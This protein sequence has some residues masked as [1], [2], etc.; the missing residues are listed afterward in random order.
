[1]NVNTKEPSTLV[2]VGGVLAL[3]VGLWLPWYAISPEHSGPIAGFIYS[4]METG[5]AFLDWFVLALLVALVLGFVGGLPS[6][7]NAVLWIF[8]G[9]LSLVVIVGYSYVTAGIFGLGEHSYYEQ[10]FVV[11]TGVYLSLAG[12][13]LLITSGVFELDPDDVT[14]SRGR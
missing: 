13:L 11:D 1:M 5:F 2:F 8:V 12:A 4:G 7:V 10:Q 9:L 6:R 3:V 14:P